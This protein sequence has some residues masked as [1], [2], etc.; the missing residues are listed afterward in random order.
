MS[1]QN[2][3]IIFRKTY[4]PLDC[5]DTCGIVAA[6]KDGKVISLSG[7]R[8]HPY[9]RGVIC[10]KMKNYHERVY[11]SDR[12]LHPMKRVGKK[13]AGSF[14]RISWDEAYSL[15]ST[16]IDDVVR[17]FGGEAI[18]PFVYAG[19]MGAVNR[20]AG[21]PLFHKIGTSRLIETICSTAASAGWVSQCGDITGTPPETAAESDVIV[22]WGSNTKVT[23]M[24]FWPYVV[25][26]KKNGARLVVI[27][28]YRNITA[29]SA[30][31]HIKVNPGGDSALAMAVLKNLIEKEKLDYTFIKERT[32]GFETLEKYLRDV[33][34]S[35][36]ADRCG[37][38]EKEI[39]LLADMLSSSSSSKIFFRLGIGMT[40]NSKAGM[41]IRAI[42]S[43]AAS[44]GLFDGGDG[45]GVLLTSGAFKGDQEKLVWSS[46]ARQETRRFNMVQLGNCLSSTDSPV[47]M[48]IVYNSNPLSAVPDGSLVR[49]ALTDED[50][51]TVVH[52]QVMTPTARYAD[53]LLPATT[54]LENRDIYT[55][56]GHFYMGIGDRVV[57]P[58]GEA[59]SNFTFFQELAEKLGFDEEPFRHD[60]DDRMKDYFN[61]LTGL[62]DGFSFEKAEAGDPVLSTRS[63]RGEAVFG[64]DKLLY[65][66]IQED[67]PSLPQHCC[68]VDG[69]EFDDA[70]YLARYPLK[71]ITPPHMDLLNST[72]GERY[73]GHPGEVLIHP[74]DAVKFSVS[75]NELITLFNSRGWCRRKARVT[76]DT[77]EGLLVAEGIF[78]QCDEHPAGI[79][80]LTS[81]KLTDMGGGGTFHESRVSI[82]VHTN[83]LKDS[84][85]EHL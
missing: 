47:K 49:N 42:T 61:S 5:P 11:R 64:A 21:Y 24:H 18:L 51:F 7:D 30:D 25:S 6:V 58:V 33:N 68:L 29:S 78:W 80:D 10:R 63:K 81:Q 82:A 19:N 15:L 65:S 52:E 83:P 26:A 14:E 41:S 17:Q 76:D 1:A 28:P 16:K 45:R 54:F 53:L 69:D 35:E 3:N 39:D 46:L 44:L 20:F 74:E 55:A 60:L 66:F 12:I 40:R 23:N 72:F 84:N 27:D 34:P 37:V 36:F 13:G 67:I 75:D 2:N 32:K 22:I 31:T 9:T 71:L 73:P 85:E 77:Q 70:D 43:L 38:A 50:L 56:Y 4:C 62:P 8:D 57:E 79:N 48:L 59:K